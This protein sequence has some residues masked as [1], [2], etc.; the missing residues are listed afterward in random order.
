MQGLWIGP[1][2]CVIMTEPHTLKWESYF[3]APAFVCVHTYVD[4]HT[5]CTCVTVSSESC[6]IWPSYL[7]RGCPRSTNLPLW[8]NHSLYK[9]FLSTY[10]VQG[11]FFFF[12]CLVDSGVNNSESGWFFLL[13]CVLEPWA[14][15]VL[16][17]A[18][19]PFISLFGKSPIQKHMFIYM[20]VWSNKHAY[21]KTFTFPNMRGRKHVCRALGENLRGKVVFIGVRT[22][23]QKREIQLCYPQC[24]ADVAVLCYSA[25]ALCT[26]SYTFLVGDSGHFPACVCV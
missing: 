15:P 22:V 21:K 17:W 18:I 1:N 3:Q 9:S 7:L 24:C 26:A 11:T 5:Q 2:T 4:G 10:Y 6:C 16:L 13:P 23:H 12:F 14:C 19:H 20:I 8:L 25:F